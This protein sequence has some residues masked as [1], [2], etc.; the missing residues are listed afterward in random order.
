MFEP[1]SKKPNPSLFWNLADHWFR[2]L[3]MALIIGTLGYLK[4][5]TANLAIAIIY[6]VSW[7]FFYNWFLE[8]GESIAEN[9]SDKKS[10]TK[11]WL[12]WFMS[13]VIVLSFFHLITAVALSVIEQ[14]I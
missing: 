13:L 14:K 11:K 7:A 10:L 3:E 12:V 8:L 6:W 2:I 4:T 1:I 5:K 9:F